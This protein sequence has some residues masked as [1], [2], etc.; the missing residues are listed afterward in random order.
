MP[1]IPLLIR[2]RH[3]RQPLLQNL[4]IRRR[5]ATIPPHFVLLMLHVIR[6]PLLANRILVL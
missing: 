1:P 3:T 5:N 2:H 4:W 6:R